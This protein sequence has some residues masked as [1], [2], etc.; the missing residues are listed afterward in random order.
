MCHAFEVSTKVGIPELIVLLIVLLPIYFVARWYLRRL[1]RYGYTRLGKICSLVNWN[2]GIIWVF[3][4]INTL[5]QPAVIPV[6]LLMQIIFVVTPFATVRTLRPG[7]RNPSKVLG[8]SLN[9]LVV[10]GALI[11]V[12]G[13]VS[14]A[15]ALALLWPFA[16]AILNLYGVSM[17]NSP[18]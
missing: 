8:L 9:G 15:Q 4:L 13:V 6:V 1:T 18:S 16:P 10:A 7:V 12:G 5:S 17:K 2:W 14:S 11:A 3:V